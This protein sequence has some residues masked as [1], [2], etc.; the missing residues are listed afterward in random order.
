MGSSGSTV[1]LCLTT[2]AIFFLDLLSFPVAEEKEGTTGYGSG[3]DN[4][5]NDAC[6]DA[7]RVRT[8]A[9]LLI[10]I[11]RCRVGIGCTGGK[12]DDNGLAGR[13]ACDENR[14]VACR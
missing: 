8:T 2:L 7:S 3:N 4:A 14:G 13:S 11:L 12:S 1:V 6:G 5:N 10:T 9:T